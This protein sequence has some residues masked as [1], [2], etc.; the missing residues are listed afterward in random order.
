MSWEGTGMV[1]ADSLGPQQP[2]LATLSPPPPHR[3]VL[4]ARGLELGTGE[5]GGG[6]GLGHGH[7]EMA[8]RERRHVL[9]G[10][11]G[12]AAGKGPPGASPWA[13]FWLWS[14]RG[15]AGRSRPPALWF[16][17]QPSA[18]FHRPSPI[19]K[20]VD[21]WRPREGSDSQ[22]AGLPVGA[23]CPKPRDSVSR[24]TLATHPQKGCA[25]EQPLPLP[26]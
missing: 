10:G 11:V 9:G 21:M 25:K 5:N 24:W 17:I 8:W 1:R 4:G 2:G 18:C 13:L 16:R 15:Q 22:A 12:T 3:A 23:D 6:T 14:R 26:L 7:Q 19:S 20:S